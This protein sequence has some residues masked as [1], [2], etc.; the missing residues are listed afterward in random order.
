MLCVC[1]RR[2]RRVK[3]AQMDALET[4]L[5]ES[6]KRIEELKER[7]T[8]AVAAAHTHA[9]NAY[10][11]NRK[12]DDLKLQLEACQEQTT[13]AEIELA[14]R[15]AEFYSADAEKKAYKEMHAAAAD[16]LRELGYYCAFVEGAGEWIE[17]PGGDGTADHWRAR[18]KAIETER[19]AENAAATQRIK[20]MEEDIAR[21][22]HQLTLRDLT[23]AANTAFT[24]ERKSAGAAAAPPKLKRAR[25]AGAES[26]T[27]DDY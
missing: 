1:V 18:C 4:A 25:P 13:D 3:L 5:E 7:L 11:A 14:T 16:K 26:D 10:L 6:E 20:Y 19:I 24:P 12:I 9:S 8:V 27:E 21:L 2:A 22:K 15:T 23:L 17:L